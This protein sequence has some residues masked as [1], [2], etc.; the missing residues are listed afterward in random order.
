MSYALGTTPAVRNRRKVVMADLDYGRAM[1]DGQPWL[2]GPEQRRLAKEFGVTTRQIRWDID[3]VL[4][5]ITRRGVDLA[6]YGYAG[7]RLDCYAKAFAHGR[8]VERAFAEHEQHMAELIERNRR[9]RISDPYAELAS[10]T[11]DRDRLAK[12]ALDE[13][14]R[15]LTAEA[16]L[17]AVRAELDRRHGRV[18]LDDILR[19][20]LD[21]E[22]DEILG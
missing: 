1:H 4:L 2:T 21:D 20:G 3:L 22:L 13:V 8:E 11:A 12:V 19:R 5:A 17:A 18:T 15:A 10:V 16:E 14:N 7:G 6:D 9:E